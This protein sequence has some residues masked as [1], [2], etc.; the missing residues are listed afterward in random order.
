MDKCFVFRTLQLPKNGDNTVK[1]YT[2]WVKSYYTLWTAFPQVNQSY[3]YKRVQLFGLQKFWASTWQDRFRTTG[4][5]GES[6]PE[7]NEYWATILLYHL[8]VIW[9]QLDKISDD[10]LD[11]LVAIH[12]FTNRI[13]GAKFHAI[14]LA[15]RC[16]QPDRFEGFLD[17]YK[18]IGSNEDLTK[19]IVRNFLPK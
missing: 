16:S 2:M 10:T 13:K 8:D 6:T 5:L 7:I 1:A 15:T 14:G 18:D 12:R 19:W 3:Y 11:Q 9:P 4:S 17:L